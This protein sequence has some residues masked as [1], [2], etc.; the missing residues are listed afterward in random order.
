MCAAF[1]QGRVHA[2]GEEAAK[3]PLRTRR[4]GLA[5]VAGGVG[6]LL[7]AEALGM[8]ATARASH[9]GPV[10]LG[11]RNEVDPGEITSI[12]SSGPRV[13]FR[14]AN[15]SRVRPTRGILGETWSPRV[16]SAGV[17]GV[18]TALGQFAA[19]SGVHGASLGGSGTG[20]LGEG[21]KRGTGVVGRS[22]DDGIGVMGTSTNGLGVYASGGG[23]ALR[24]VG[25]V[26]M[27]GP[28]EIGHPG[29]GGPVLPPVL[30]V[31]PFPP[32]TGD[33]ALLLGRNFGPPQRV[34]V[35]APD[36]GGPGFRALRVPN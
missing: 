29:F 16:G 18:A 31:D 19:G 10:Q 4:E 35:G 25:N 34:S 32:T 3:R 33:T 9:L 21:H 23:S 2:T 5:A 8:P 15:T 12:V 6:G 1:L 7:A 11:H 22:R 14:V 36:S 17:R 28:L 30:R 13:A 27:T 26:T 20:V 24:A